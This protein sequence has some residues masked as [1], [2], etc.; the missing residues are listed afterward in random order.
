MDYTMNGRVQSRKGNQDRIRAPHNCYRCQGDDKWVSIAVSTEGEWQAFCEAIGNPE[1]TGDERFCDAYSRWKNQE[2]LDRLVGE[3][4]INYTHYEVTEC[5]QK[6]GVAA[7]P[8]LS[9]E[10]IISDAHFKER[11]LAVEIEHPVM[12]KQ[13]VVGP[14][15]RLSETPAR[16][17]KSSPLIG[18]HNEYVFGE[19]L[20]M[21]SEEIA[22]LMDEE[23]IY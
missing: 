2:E 17:T 4:T 20:G 5:L 3:W 15:W 16:V 1:W 11:N 14:P 7:M 22:R 19:L 18:E 12:G 10:E 23:I 9:N 13:L 6:A 8:S 21:S